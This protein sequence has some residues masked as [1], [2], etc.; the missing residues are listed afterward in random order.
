MA[1]GSPPSR[2][3]LPVPGPVG[4]NEPTA[5]LLPGDQPAVAATGPV[6]AWRA[7]YVV[8]ATAAAALCTLLLQ[9][10]NEIT[11]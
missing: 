9:E 1:V 7:C 5:Y 6:P 8:S 4:D 2:N 10:D 3:R 11:S